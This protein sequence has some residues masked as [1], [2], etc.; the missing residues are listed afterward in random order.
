M[1]EGC[2]L[3]HQVSKSTHPIE[4]KKQLYPEPFVM[5]YEGNMYLSL[6]D[7]NSDFNYQLTDIA[8][9]VLLEGILRNGGMHIVPLDLPSG[10][11]RM[12]LNGA[13]WEICRKVFV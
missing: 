11:Y 7:L 8:G 6:H 13:G 3:Y 12:V 5:A 2:Y 1:T 9:Q 10:I 4:V